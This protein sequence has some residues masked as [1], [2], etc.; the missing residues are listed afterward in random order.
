M[1]LAAPD[2]SRLSVTLPQTLVDYFA[3]PLAVYFGVM[4]TE[5]P[6]TRRSVVLSQ[7][8]ITGDVVP[9]CQDDF[10]TGLDTNVWEVIAASPSSIQAVPANAYWLNWTQPDAGFVLTTNSNSAAPNGWGTN[11][12]PTPVFTQGYM[13]STLLTTNSAFTANPIAFPANGSLFFRLQRLGW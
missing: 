7:I 4:V 8:Q 2:G 6:N 5:I 12:L 3:A 10:S 1:T 11:Q 13:R 9:A